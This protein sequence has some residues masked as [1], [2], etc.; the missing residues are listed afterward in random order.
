MVSQE[1]IRELQKLIF[2]E[3][4]KELNWNEATSV[5]NTLVDYFDLLSQMYW[6]TKN[7]SD[8]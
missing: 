8:E 2:E 6:Q 7:S 4:D 5:A 3:Y 1:R